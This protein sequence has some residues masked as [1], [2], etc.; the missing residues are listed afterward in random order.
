M[1]VPSKIIALRGALDTGIDADLSA[2]ETARMYR[3]FTSVTIALAQYAGVKGVRL[4]ELTVSAA[5][6]QDRV[7]GDGI[8]EGARAV[9]DLLGYEP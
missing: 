4:K 7:E 3:V 9:L 1:S 5:L 6:A 2:D 8:N